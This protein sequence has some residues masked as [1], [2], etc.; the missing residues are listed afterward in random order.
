MSRSKLSFF[1][2]Q[3]IHQLNHSQFWKC[4]PCMIGDILAASFSK[5]IVRTSVCLASRFIRT[6]KWQ[7]NHVRSE[8]LIDWITQIDSPIKK[9]EPSSSPVGAGS[10][11]ETGIKN[12]TA[13]RTIVPEPK[14]EEVYAM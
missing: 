13:E 9:I 11:T 10:V 1:T 14:S 6:Q 2:L 3:K 12:P 5:S 7:S 4:I 8:L